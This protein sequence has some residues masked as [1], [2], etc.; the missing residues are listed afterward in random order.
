VL[1]LK[2]ITKFLGIK[3][4]CGLDRNV[5]GKGHITEQNL[6]KRVTQNPPSLGLFTFI[7]WLSIDV[8]IV[9]ITI[10]LLCPKSGYNHMSC[11]AP[12][13]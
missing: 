9:V 3:K 11:R 1:I 13:I 5:K 2:V 8:G 10:L 6:K 4:I 12:K 7:V